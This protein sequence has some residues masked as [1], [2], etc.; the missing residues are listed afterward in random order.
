MRTVGETV[1]LS[2]LDYLKAMTNGWVMIGIALL[3]CWLISQLSLLSWADLTFVL[4]ITAVSYVLAALLGAISLREHVSIS[5][6]AGVGL[7]FLGVVLVGRTRPR[8]APVPEGENS[9]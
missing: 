1:S 4:P 8:T 5:R 7:I 9:G 2:P 3:I 6:W